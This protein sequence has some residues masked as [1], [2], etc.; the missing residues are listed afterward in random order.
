M[1]EQ[2]DSHRATRILI[3][4]AALAIITGGIREAQSVLE[5]FLVAVFLAAIGTPSVL[6]LEQKG[7]PYVVAVFFA[8]AGMATD[9][10]FI[11]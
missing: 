2:D 10:V 11:E 8:V 4:V 5:W 9:K 3:I 7:I 6:W 1:A